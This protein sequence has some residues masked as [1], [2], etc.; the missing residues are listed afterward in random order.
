MM[1]IATKKILFLNIFLVFSTISVFSHPFYVSICQIDFNR[2]SQSLEISVKTFADDLLLALEK[3]GASKLF[4][5][6]GKENPAADNLISKYLKSRLQIK[7]NGKKGEMKWIGKE[8]ETDAVWS[9][10]EIDHISALKEIE[11]NCTLLTEIYDSQNNIIQINLGGNIKS[12]LLD[13]KKT[14]EVM[15]F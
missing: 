2:E 9:Y 13:K 12:M 4:L 6:E 15:K 8:M 14:V 5:G 3:E 10:L 11:V 7:V 1:M